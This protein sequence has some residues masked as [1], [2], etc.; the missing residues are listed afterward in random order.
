MKNILA[1]TTLLCLLGCESFEDYKSKDSNIISGLEQNLIE[2]I[3]QDDEN[4]LS[5]SSS[6]IRISEI[7]LNKEKLIEECKSLVISYVRKKNTVSFN[8]SLNGNYYI[9]KK[10]GDVYLYLEFCAENEHG[11]AQEFTGECK[12][13]RDGQNEVTISG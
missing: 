9:N 11:N 12:F 6:F 4:N 7:N 8:N 13:P 10:T 2:N 5:K 1:F 3:N